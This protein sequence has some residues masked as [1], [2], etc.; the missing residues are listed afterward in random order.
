MPIQSDFPKQDTRKMVLAIKSISGDRELS[1]PKNAIALQSKIDHLN[2]EYL[3]K[4]GT[5]VQASA[6]PVKEQTIEVAI[7]PNEIDLGE[8]IPIPPIPKVTNQTVEIPIQL[9]PVEPDT[10]FSTPPRYNINV[11]IN[12]H[13]T[14][15]VFTPDDLNDG[16]PPHTSCGKELLDKLGIPLTVKPTHITDELVPVQPTENTETV[17]PNEVTEKWLGPQKHVIERLWRT[18]VDLNVGGIVRHHF[19]IEVEENNYWTSTL[20]RSGLAPQDSFLLGSDFFTPGTVKVT[21]QPLKLAF[22]GQI[23]D[24]DPAGTP[25]WVQALSTDYENL[26]AQETPEIQNQIRLAK[27][28]YENDVPQWRQEEAM[29]RLCAS[30]SKAIVPLLIKRLYQAGQAGLGEQLVRND[31]LEPTI[32]AV[33]GQKV[34]GGPCW[35]RPEKMIL[36][37]QDLAQWWQKNKDTFAFPTNVSRLFTPDRFHRP[38]EQQKQ[39]SNQ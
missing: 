3:H 23:T 10:G 12:G 38:I 34:E 7:W 1:F 29:T 14:T 32:V 31:T 28:D 39:L 9:R 20:R 37:A 2:K 5:T 17:Q 36:A 30:R 33:T 18:T 24:N 11:E 26:I 27:C 16:N 19:P 22:T 21:T 6:G 15:A 13:K 25:D 4:Y 8:K 35:Y